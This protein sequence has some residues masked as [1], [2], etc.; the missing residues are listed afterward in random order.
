[1]P[2]GEK[3]TIVAAPSQSHACT[4]KCFL[5]PHDFRRIHGD[6]GGVKH[7]SVGAAQAVRINNTNPSEQGIVLTRVLCCSPEATLKR[8]CLAMGSVQRQVCGCSVGQASV[9]EAFDASAL[10]SLALATVHFSVEHMGP[11]RRPSPSRHVA[12]VGSA[13]PWDG[14]ELNRLCQERFRGHVLQL[15]QR[16]LFRDFGDRYYYRL[17][18]VALVTARLRGRGLLD[19]SCSASDLELVP[20]GVLSPTT[21]ASFSQFQHPGLVTAASCSARQLQYAVGGAMPCPIVL[22]KDAVGLAVARAALLLAMLGHARLA[23]AARLL[24]IHRVSAHEAK[25]L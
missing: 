20:A 9:A 23:E 17:E 13:E 8:G 6:G 12:Q 24:C 21:A 2:R 25:A 14:E 18:V 10:E 1:M 22:A 16:L 3:F 7:M 4:N 11:G 5:H 19:F 15:G